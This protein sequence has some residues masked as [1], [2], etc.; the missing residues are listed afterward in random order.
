MCFLKRRGCSLFIRVLLIGSM[1]IFHKLII[2]HVLLIRKI[3]WQFLTSFSFFF[4]RRRRVRRK[5]NLS[6]RA[7][8]RRRFRAISGANIGDIE[9][10]NS[11]D[12]FWSSRRGGPF[13]KRL[14]IC[15]S[16]LGGRE[17]EAE[18]GLLLSI[19]CC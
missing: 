10:R 8:R 11:C 17:D 9:L 15:L 18:A 3:V 6:R 5:N 2:D 19:V 12:I 13:L 4:Y 14:A 16:F 1:H 7:G